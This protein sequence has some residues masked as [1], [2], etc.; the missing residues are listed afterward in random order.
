MLCMDEAVQLCFEQDVCVPTWQSPLWFLHSACLMT[1][2]GCCVSGP[3]DSA[4]HA[5]RSP[6]DQRVGLW[7]HAVLLQDLLWDASEWWA[8]THTHP[9]PLLLRVLSGTAD[10]MLQLQPHQRMLHTLFSNFVVLCVYAS[11]SVFIYLVF[12]HHVPTVVTHL[13]GQDLHM[14]PY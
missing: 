13:G 8:A 10:C 4:A 12:D 14:G 3:Q 9:H 6:P 5:G 2:V 1:L 11:S 7:D